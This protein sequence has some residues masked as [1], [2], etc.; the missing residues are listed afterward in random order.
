MGKHWT[1][2]LLTSTTFLFLQLLSK[3]FT[4]L[5]RWKVVTLA[6][7]LL[8]S[9]LTLSQHLGPKKPIN[10]RGGQEQSRQL[11]ELLIQHLRT[12]NIKN[13]LSHQL[14]KQQRPSS[15][16]ILSSQNPFVDPISLLS[17]VQKT[18]QQQPKNSFA[19]N[20]NQPM[21]LSGPLAF[22][23]IELTKEQPQRQLFIEAGLYSNG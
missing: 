19:M 23:L 12:A 20:N 16:A 5:K 3:L 4:V 10:T 22:M 17:V 13:M 15:S 18:A 11:L 14:S 7:A 1:T 8:Y 9:V 6:D 2:F 21:E